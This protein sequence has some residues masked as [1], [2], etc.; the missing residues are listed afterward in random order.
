M[1]LLPL[2]LSFFLM[3][4]RPPRSTL[5]PYTTLFRSKI[6]LVE[7]G[8][9][10]E[11]GAQCRSRILSFQHD[12]FGERFRTMK[13]KDGAAA[14]VWLHEVGEASF[15]AGA[16]VTE[17]QGL[18][19]RLQLVGKA[20]TVFFG[21]DFVA[22]ESFAFFFGFDDASGDGIDVEKIVRLAVA[23]VH[24]ELSDGY[25]AA[26]GNVGFVAGL[27]NP[28]SIGEETVDI[29]PCAGFGGVGHDCER[30]IIT[31]AG[32]KAGG[33]RGVSRGFINRSTQDGAGRKNRQYGAR[34]RGKARPRA[35]RSGPRATMFPRRDENLSLTGVH[36]AS[37]GLSRAER[38]S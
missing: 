35:G 18:A 36:E 21:L 20:D 30:S 23:G 37:G 4:R 19:V 8:K 15:D 2:L 26:G 38:G 32:G 31:A 13:R 5:F 14:S 10:L 3:I 24:R 1:P 9:M 6:A 22:G 28:A 17:G 34:A 29:L 25:A 27:H 12:P 33:S 16:L 11:A 7:R